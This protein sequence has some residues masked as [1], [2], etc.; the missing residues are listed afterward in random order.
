MPSKSGRSLHTAL[1]T[2]RG[3]RVVFLCPQSRAVLCTRSVFSDFRTWEYFGFYALKVGPFSAR[4]VRRG[5]GR[6]RQVSMP[7]N[8]GRSLHLRRST[9]GRG[10]QRF[11]CPQTRAVLCTCIDVG[12]QGA[13]VSF[14]CPQTRAVLCTQNKA[15]AAYDRIRFY[16]LKLGPFS[17]PAAADGNV[18]YKFLCPQTRAV[19]CTR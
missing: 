19:L 9:G 5:G 4:R 7:S 12:C 11:L 15:M 3:F 13:L 6:S 10:H 1:V 16:A 14:L 8:S 2:G 17:A 18:V